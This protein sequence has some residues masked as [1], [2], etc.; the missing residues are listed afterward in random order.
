MPL[1][2]RRLFDTAKGCRRGLKTFYLSATTGDLKGF[3]DVL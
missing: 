2:A 3:C 1:E